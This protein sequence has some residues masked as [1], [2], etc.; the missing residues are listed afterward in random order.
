VRLFERGV[1]AIQ[2]FSGVGESIGIKGNGEKDLAIIFSSALCSA[3]GV[4]TRNRVK[5]APVVVTKRHLGNGKAQAIVASSGIANACTGKRGIRDAEEMAGLAARVLGVK[6]GNVL[7][8]S[9]G[10]IGAFLPMEKIRR[11]IANCKGKLRKDDSIAEAILTTDAV[12]KQLLVREDNFSIAAIAKGSGMVSPNM[13]TMLCFICTDAMIG[14]KRLQRML[15]KAVDSSFNMLSVDADTST[16]DM[17]VILANGQAGKINEGKFQRALDL[18]CVEMAKKIARDGEGA[19]KL[20]TAIVD[21]AKTREDAAKA[22]KAIVSS[23]LVKCAVFGSDPNWGRIM[24]AIGRSGAKFRPGSVDISINGWRIVKNGVQGGFD[25][26]KVRDSMKKSEVT[27]KVNLKGGRE[28][29]TAFGCDLS[30]E[31]VEINAMYTT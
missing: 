3:A 26:Q 31:Y 23:S 17:C 9:T 4:F 28:R 11:G 27:I 22:A 24:A 10:L 21:N 15:R 29:A 2:G 18:L 30:P 12:R 16:S 8:A 5:G 1:T 14:S 20:L 19:T 25:R 7:V 6:K 13:A